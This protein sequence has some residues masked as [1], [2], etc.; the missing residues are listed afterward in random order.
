MLEF[1]ILK[2]YNTAQLLR[3]Q[4]EIYLYTSIF[5]EK[6][7]RIVGMIWFYFDRVF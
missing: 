2:Y 4:L 1:D 6:K 3:Q 7:K 5:Q